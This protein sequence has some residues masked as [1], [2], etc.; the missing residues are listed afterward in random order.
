MIELEEAQRFIF[1]QCS[2]LATDEVEISK[3]RGLVLAE[4]VI[5]KDDVPSFPNTAMDGY[6]VRAVDTEDAPVELKVVGTLPAGKVPDLEVG[7]DEAVRIMT[8]AVIPEGAD[9]VVMVE[10]TKEAANGNS[11]IVEET[12]KNGNFIRQPGEDFVRGSELFTSGTLI[13]A[14]HIGVFATIGLEKVTVF[15]RPIVGVMST[16]DELVQ[17]VSQLKPGQIRDS[18]RYSIKALLE[19][20]GVETIDLGLIPDDEKAIESALLSAIG[21]CDAV[22]TSGGVSMGDFDYV[23]VVLDRL[24]EMKWMQVA[25]NPAKPL[26]FGLLDGVP[27]FGLPG[28]PVSAMVSFELFMRPTL[29][30]IMGYK[31]IWRPYLKAKAVT[32]LKRRKDG[33]VHFARVTLIR[34]EDSY[35]VSLLEGQGSHQLAAMAN[36][37]GLAVLPNGEGVKKGDFVDVMQLTEPE[38]N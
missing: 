10:K 18:N 21:K 33:K 5:S 2:K 23:K 36:A 14:A 4:T 38:I 19:E 12:V 25:I 8:G 6:A 9:S 11:V 22:V 35:E 13:G 15:K 34:K 37:Q 27:I 32:P 20:M 7:P 24:G 30:K 17:G 1:S 28:N 16:G 31:Q 26:A 29:L 3:S